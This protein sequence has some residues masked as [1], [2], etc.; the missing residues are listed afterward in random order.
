MRPLPFVLNVRIILHVDK[1]LPHT[2]TSILPQSNIHTVYYPVVS[3]FS[4]FAPTYT[5]TLIG[6][7]LYVYISTHTL[8]LYT[9]LQNRT[10]HSGGLSPDENCEQFSIRF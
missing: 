9:L 6:G 3:F 10:Y 2:T 4:T 7:V 8:T 1:S 5:F